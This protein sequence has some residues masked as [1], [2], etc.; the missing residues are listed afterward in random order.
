M[1]GAFGFTLEKRVIA[2]A[3]DGLCNIER[4]FGCTHDHARFAFTFFDFSVAL[5]CSSSWR[6]SFSIK[7]VDIPPTSKGIEK[8]PSATSTQDFLFFNIWG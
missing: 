2:D 3:L 4:Y 6:E 7:P 8:V 5:F 1:N